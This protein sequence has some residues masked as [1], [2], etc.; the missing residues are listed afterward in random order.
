MSSNVKPI[1][2]GYHSVTPYLIVKGAAAA[3]EFYKKVFA[4][5]E[6]MRM[7]GPDG[8]IGHAEIRIGDSAVMLADEHPDMGAKSPQT[9]GGSPVSL[10][11]YVGDADAVVR[12]AIAA[13]A[14]LKEP[15]TDKFYG[16]RMGGLTDPFGHVWFVAT[17][18]EDVTPEEMKKRVAALHGPK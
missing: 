18:I 12:Q 8:K 16:D 1:P 13:G 15:V 14:Q 6:I 10:L 11:V 4:A 7:P 3:I 17:H 9:L 5:A 2:D